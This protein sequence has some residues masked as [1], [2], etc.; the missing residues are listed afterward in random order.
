MYSRRQYLHIPHALV[1]RRQAK[2]MAWTLPR[3][4]LLVRSG[5][6]RSA[7]GAGGR[8]GCKAARVSNLQLLEELLQLV[9]QG[10]S[11]GL[12][13]ASCEEAAGRPCSWLLL[14]EALHIPQHKPAKAKHLSAI[15]ALMAGT[16]VDKHAAPAM[17]G[18]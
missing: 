5:V 3:A 10:M 2:T 7:A 8:V 14:N 18:L 1:A 13:A 11:C 12:A 9:L 4:K 6:A 17:S 16:I 15:A